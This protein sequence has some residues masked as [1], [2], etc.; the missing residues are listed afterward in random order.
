MEKPATK[1]DL[2]HLSIPELRELM[3]T[4]ADEALRAEARRELI[5]C[6]VSPEE[7]T[8]KRPFCSTCGWRCGGTDS[9]NGIACKCGKS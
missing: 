8:S 2:S 7:P 9:W 1:P 3:R 5:R 6:A 4:T